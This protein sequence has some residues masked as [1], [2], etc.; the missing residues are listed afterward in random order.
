M[1]I[2]PREWTRVCH[3]DD[4]PR[5]GGR[6]LQLGS[7]MVAVF[8]TSH[9]SVMVMENRCPH[10]GGVLSEGIVT[11]NNVICP[12]HGWKIDMITGEA[13]RPDKGCVYVFPVDVRNGEVYVDTSE[14]PCP[15]EITPLTDITGIYA[16]SKRPK[17]GVR[18]AQP[19]DFTT[20]DFS[21]DIPV[22]A[23][24]PPSPDTEESLQLEIVRA[25]CDQRATINIEK[26]RRWFEPI[27]LPTYITCLMFDF[28][29]PVTWTGVRLMDVLE[30]LEMSDDFLFASFYSWDTDETTEQDR[31]F[32]T[33]NRDYVTDP[34][35]MLVFE[36]NG[37][38]LPKKHGGPLRL[39]VPFLQGYK[40]VKWLSLI[41]LCP[42]DEIGY[43]RLHGFITFP[44]FH[45]PAA[46]KHSDN[47][48]GGTD[49]EEAAS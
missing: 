32:E 31:F 15:G 17:L 8:R 16:D 2:P 29:S 45:P 5:R 9:G 24:E 4:I 1:E 10:K 11:G 46:M 47:A 18:R 26:L 44:E 22:L 40:S 21:G 3:V 41:K 30:R 12:L 37:K 14:L 49:I 48:R 7:M 28:S 39:V 27:T 35:T 33:L 6:A 36:M 25:D 20:H 43:K 13:V 19:H 34:R 23:V 42:Q 38:P